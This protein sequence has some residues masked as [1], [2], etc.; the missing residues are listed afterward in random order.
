[1]LLALSLAL[2][3]SPGSDPDRC[4]HLIAQGRAMAER[5]GARPWQAYADTLDGFAATVRGDYD[6]AEQIIRRAAEGFDSMDPSEWE[7]ILGGAMPEGMAN[8]CWCRYL[9][10]SNAIGA[11]DYAGA[12]RRFQEALV[13]SRGRVSG[14]SEQGEAVVLAAHALASLAPLA[15]EAGESGRASALAG[16][17]LEIVARLGL[18]ATT[19]LVLTR[20]AE[21]A[22]L[23]GDDAGAPAVLGRLLALLHRLG[24]ANFAADAL[25]TAALVAATAGDP[26]TAARLVGAS[27]AIRQAQA[28]PLG[29]TRVLS[30]LVA[31]LPARLANSL[32]ASEWERQVAAGR[33]TPMDTALKAALEAV[34]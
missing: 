10:G 9:L 34:A 5:L 15:A 2:N 28:Q 30:G 26:A 20:A 1:M 12:G 31:D 24:T 14:R 32:G 13:M 27:Q 23:A 3:D 17:A 19:A 7:E 21:A 18:P 29:G 6:R 8:S 11:R 22:V 33:S 25:E 16:E 4:A